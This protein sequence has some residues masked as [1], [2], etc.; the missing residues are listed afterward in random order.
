M[1]YGSDTLSY[2]YSNDFLLGHINERERE[3]IRFSILANN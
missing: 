3:I 1:R 2:F